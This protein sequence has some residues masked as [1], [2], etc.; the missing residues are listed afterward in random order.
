M[1]ALIDAAIS[2]SRTVLATLMLILIAGAVAYWQ[3]PKEAD[4]DINIPIIYVSIAH[5]GISPEDA[6]RLLVRPLEQELRTVEGVEEMRST[7]YQGGAYVILEFDA[8][9][10]ADKALADVRDKVDDAGPEL[11][12]DSDEPTVNEVNTAMFPAILVTLSGEVPERTLRRVARDLEDKIEAITSVLE[13]KIAGDRDEQVEIVIDPL[14][15]ES[16]RLSGQDIIASVRRSNLLVAAGSVDTGHGRFAVK[17]PGLFETIDDVLDMPVR[18]S[19]DAVVT[20]RDIAVVRRGFK[21]PESFSRLNGRPAITLE[22]SKRSGENIIATIQQVR[23]VVE[24]EREAWP[25][26]VKVT[27]SQDR[28]TYIQNMLTDLQNSVISAVLLVMIVVVAALGLRS[29]GLVGVAV[30]GSFLTAILFLAT[31]G[32]TINIVVLFSLILAVGMLVDGAIVVVE[33]ADREMSEGHDRREAYARAAKR[34]A[35]PIIASTATTLAAFFPL[36]FW[37]GVVGEFMKFLPITLLA[38]LSASLAMALVFVPTLGAQIG[39]PGGVVDVAAMGGPQAGETSGLSGLRGMTGAY[40]QVLGVALKHPAKVLLGAVVLLVAVQWFYAAHGNGVE[41]FPEIEP[42]R[43]ALQIRARGNLSVEEQ[44]ALVAEAEERVLAIGAERGEFRSV[45]T[46]SGIVGTIQIEFVA[47]DQRRPAKAILKDILHR[48]KPIAGIIIEAREEE[49]G[50]SAG[51]PIQLELSARDLKLLAPAVA[52]V[53]GGLRRVGGLKNIEDSRPLRGIEWEIQVDRAQAAKYGADVSAVGS[54]VQM[55]TNGLVIS[56]YRPD[57]SVDEIDIVARFPVAYRTIEQL[58]QIR[59]QSEQGLVPITNFVSRVPQPK[60][61]TINRT[62]FRRVMTVKADVEDGILTNDKVREIRDWL[63]TAD[64]DPG[65]AILFKGEDKEQKEAEV[66]LLRAF[67]IALFAMAI[68]LVTQF[69]RFYS[70]LLILSAVIMSTIGVMIGLLI[71]GQPFGI[72]MSGVGVIALAGIV[73]NNNIV[74]IDTFD[75]LKVTIVDAREAILRTGA[76]RLRP[77]LLTTITTI[78]G[79]MPMVLGVNINFMTREVAAGAPSSQWWTQL[80]SA[81][82]F[83]LGFATVLT[84]VVTPCALMVRANVQAW[85]QREPAT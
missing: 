34:M 31:V 6:E 17:V 36:L 42:E 28:S 11:P 1:N 38:T 55:V 14:L 68:I 65:V 47:W 49:A 82:V 23:A 70:A 32:L 48:T 46:R 22:V 58:D 26:A 75:R 52:K 62:D 59:L 21:D 85:R 56:E 20:V 51:K 80:S 29:A 37:P 40:I 45:Y 24:A 4:P 64:L 7:A 5:K 76:Q 19:G 3:I 74:L 2:H 35:W 41:F 8:G 83:G 43:A 16:Y 13:A 54:A 33:Y 39:R 57:D 84:L 18:V 79:L 73:V 53:L 77:V 71:I 78:L 81:I 25:P 30:P 10:D 50:P 69:N 72:V 27:Y 61:G 15:A 44:D 12:E 60:V 9:F 67:S 66:F 63:V